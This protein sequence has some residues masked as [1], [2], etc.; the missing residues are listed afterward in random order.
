MKELVRRKK[1]IIP[2]NGYIKPLGIRGP[3]SIPFMATFERIAELLSNGIPVTEIL[4]DGG[5]VKLNLVN[6]DQ[7]NSTHENSSIKKTFESI[8][9]VKPV[10]AAPTVVTDDDV[11]K[12]SME[13]ILLKSTKVFPEGKSVE[14]EDRKAVESL[15]EKTYIGEPDKET[16][17]QPA[18]TNNGK[19]KHSRIRE[20]IIDRR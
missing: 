17:K 15:E 3:V 19:K 9:R 12:N 2:Y 4:N 14:M 11:K 1:V 5:K 6:F 10:S 7:C 18:N 13:Q 16:V 8:R 20:E